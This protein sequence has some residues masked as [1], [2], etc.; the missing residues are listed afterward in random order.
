METLELETQSTLDQWRL[1]LEQILSAYAKLPYRYGEISTY[2][3]ISQDRNHFLLMH[4]GWENQHRIHGCLVH[5]EIRN[6]KIWIHY[7]GI[8]DSITEELVQFGVPKTSIVLA[9][10]SPEV[11]QHTGYAAS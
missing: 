4:E 3:I 9:F 1:L 11:R 6:Q 7:D 10:H 5:A 2:P 8:E